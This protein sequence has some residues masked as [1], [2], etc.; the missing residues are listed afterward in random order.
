LPT[1]QEFLVDWDPHTGYD[2]PVFREQVAEH[3]LK[4]AFALLERKQNIKGNAPIG[5]LMLMN[6]GIEVVAVTATGEVRG[7]TSGPS[8]LV[9]GESLS[10]GGH[11]PSEHHDYIMPKG[12]FPISLPDDPK[13]EKLVLLLVHPNEKPRLEQVGV[14]DLTAKTAP[15]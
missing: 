1:H 3:S 11:S 13:I 2:H 8:L 7:L 4:H 6:L 15:K 14:I 10:I 5:L 12:A 9:Q